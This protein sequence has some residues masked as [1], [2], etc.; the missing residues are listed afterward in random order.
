MDE[1]VATMVEV[2]NMLH[3]SKLI[4]KHNSESDFYL[5]M[6]TVMSGGFDFE[7]SDVFMP[8]TTPH[9]LN[10]LTRAVEC[11]WP[12]QAH[13]DGAFNLCTKIFGVIGMGMKSMGTK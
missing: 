4:E 5:D 2:G 6:H 13:F 11:G 1:T 7:G 3:I 12:P 10:N 9:L 8:P